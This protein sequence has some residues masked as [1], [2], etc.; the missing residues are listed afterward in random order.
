RQDLSAEQ[1]LGGGPV[2]DAPGGRVA[3]VERLL[4]VLA[5]LRD[6]D[7]GYVSRSQLVD[8]IAAYRSSPTDAAVKKAMQRDVSTLRELGFSIDAH[9]RL[10]WRA[11]GDWRRR[12]GGCRSTS[13]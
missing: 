9:E 11:A 10:G 5:M 12:R 4:Q 1:T 6:A 7:G 2:H 8:K 3:D 13:T